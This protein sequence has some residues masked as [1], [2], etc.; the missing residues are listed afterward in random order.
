[1]DV[2][3]DAEARG[4]SSLFLKKYQ[5]LESDGTQPSSLCHP[6]YLKKAVRPCTIEPC[7]IEVLREGAYKNKLSILLSIGAYLYKR[8]A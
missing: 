1:M 6:I 2:S 7:T 3:T 5:V 4:I 8:D